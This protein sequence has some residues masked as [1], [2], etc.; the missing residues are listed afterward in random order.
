MSDNAKVLT[1]QHFESLCLE[2]ICLSNICKSYLENRRKSYMNV[3]KNQC[4]NSHNG[5]DML[6]DYNDMN[7][8]FVT[9][10]SLKTRRPSKISSCLT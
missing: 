1:K 5:V 2:S 10:F 9:I 4:S 7:P 6:F 8:F 3:T